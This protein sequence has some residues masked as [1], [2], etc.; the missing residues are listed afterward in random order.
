M[1][2][3]IK[4]S[5]KNPYTLLLDLLLV[6]IG[7]EGGC[8]AAAE[9]LV[10]EYFLVKDMPKSVGGITMVRK[11]GLRSILYYAFH[12]SSRLKSIQGF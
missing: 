11:R 5:E 12:L 10:G 2:G 9:S 4:K 8:G 6:F 1:E 3:V 7:V